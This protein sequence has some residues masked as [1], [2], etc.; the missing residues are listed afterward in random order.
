M[1]KYKACLSQSFLLGAELNAVIGAMS[2]LLQH[3]RV[4]VKQ[5]GRE[6]HLDVGDRM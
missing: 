5:G 2:Q 6:C 4:I 1:V 3:G